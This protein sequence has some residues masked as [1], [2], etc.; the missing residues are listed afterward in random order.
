M[1]WEIRQGGPDCP[2]GVYNQDTGEHIACHSCI[3]MA[4]MRRII[5]IVDRRGE[6]ER[7]H[8]LILFASTTAA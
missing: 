5:Y 7:L 6:V 4:D 8:L 3:R 2:F 1:A